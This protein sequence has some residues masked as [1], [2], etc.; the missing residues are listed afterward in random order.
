MSCGT[1]N[2]DYRSDYQPFSLS[3]TAQQYCASTG[4][5]GLSDG[6]VGSCMLIGPDLEN[7]HFPGR[8]V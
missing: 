3:V 8:A 5:L 2:L 4:S 7:E 6:Y 1:L